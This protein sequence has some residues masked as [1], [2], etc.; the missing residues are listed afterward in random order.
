MS[1]IISVVLDNIRVGFVLDM[2]T[3]AAYFDAFADGFPLRCRRFLAHL[4]IAVLAQELAFQKS[5]GCGPARR[6]RYEQPAQ[7]TLPQP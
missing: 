5:E 3:A 4:R 7:P 1:R 6:G 2:A